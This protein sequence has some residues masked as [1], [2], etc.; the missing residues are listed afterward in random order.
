MQRC[1]A[2]TKMARSASAESLHGLSVLKI[3]L[4]EQLLS[5]N[6]TFFHSESSND[7]NIPMS[8]SLLT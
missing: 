8:C 1:P 7:S 4:T 3:V 6:I 5:K 2:E